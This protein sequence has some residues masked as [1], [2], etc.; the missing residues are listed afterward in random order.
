MNFNPLDIISKGM[1]I[2]PQVTRILFG[3]VVLI[4]CV[5]LGGQLVK[6]PTT[7]IVGGI[8]FVIASVIL[9]VVAAIAAAAKQLGSIAIWFARFICAAFIAILLVLLSAWSMDIPKPLPCLISPFS[10]CRQFDVKARQEASPV[11]LCLRADEKLTSASCNGGN[12]VV[13][14]VRWDDPD[15]GLNVRESGDIK[16]TIRGVLKP[17][18]TNLTVDTCKDGWCEVEC[19]ALKGWSRDRYLSLRENVLYKVSGISKA[20]I[21]LAIRNGPDQTCSAVDSIPY[22][23]RDVIIHTCE[24]SPA[25]SSRWCLVTYKDHSGWVPLENLVRQE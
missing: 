14:N 16:T 3:G 18:T 12:Y 1:K 4:A 2:N 21:G 5:A 11:S 9:I 15:H 25:G 8:L 13:T 6:D 24:V 23:G 20:A 7:A 19:K 10:P 17:N 22:D